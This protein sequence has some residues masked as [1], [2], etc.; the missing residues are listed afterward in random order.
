M[1]AGLVDGGGSFGF[2]VEVAEVAGVVGLAPLVAPGPAGRSDSGGWPTKKILSDVVSA[3]VHA[4]GDVRHT[5]LGLQPGSTTYAIFTSFA[6][7]PSARILPLA[8]S[9]SVPAKSG[10]KNHARPARYSPRHGSCCCTR[11]FTGIL[12]DTGLPGAGIW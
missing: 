11:S 10:I 12:V 3:R 9:T 8:A 6:V 1:S 5:V 7:K 2:S 4:S